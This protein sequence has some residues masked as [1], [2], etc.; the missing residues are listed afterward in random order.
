[1]TFHQE[2]RELGDALQ[3]R[4]SD[5]NEKT[6]GKLAFAFIVFDVDGV[7]PCSFSSNLSFTADS[8]SRVWL[9][10]YLRQT[11]DVLLEMEG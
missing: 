3:K 7:E 4:F 8:H 11:A 6:K 10:H 1:M 9:A 5:M 2:A